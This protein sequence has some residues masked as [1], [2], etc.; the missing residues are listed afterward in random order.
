MAR[1]YFV[2]HFSIVVR[3]HLSRSGGSFHSCC[4]STFFFLGYPYMQYPRALLQG[5][6][7][8]LRMAYDWTVSRPLINLYLLGPTQ[9][10]FWGGKSLPDMCAEISQAKAS[11]W[12]SNPEEC[13]DLVQHKVGSFL[14]LTE[15]LIYFGCLL[16]IVFAL[17][18]RYLILSPLVASLRSMSVSP[19]KSK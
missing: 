4:H 10:G 8:A 18:Y 13:T 17:F 19:K 9:L 16:A 15:T 6:G 5:L 3:L 2:I 11:F 14:V 1:D 7:S 12:I